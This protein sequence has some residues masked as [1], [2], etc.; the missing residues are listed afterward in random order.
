MDF[1]R[2]TIDGHDLRI[3]RVAEGG[4]PTVVMTNAFPQ[5]IRCWESLWDRLAER[6]D[7]V[8]VDLAGFG[9]S[10]GTPEEMRP[11]AQADLLVR[12]LDDLGIDRTFLVGPDVGVPVS[13][14]LAST[15]SERLHGVNV[16][17]G[18]GTWPTDFDPALGAAVRSRLVRWLAARAPMRRRLMAQNLDAA[19]SAGYHHFTPSAE[20]VEEYRSICFDEERHRNSLAFLGSYA[21]ELPKIEERLPSVTVPVLVTWGAH[22]RFVRPSNAERLQQLLPHS[23]LTV[24]EHAGHFSHEDADGEWLD[25]F[26][27]FVDSHHTTQDHPT[28]RSDR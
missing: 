23:E 28:L 4:R 27:A 8:A 13:L 6:V 26:L 10:S 14:W 18:P 22:D 17:D 7:L 5:S 3:A 11:S 19:T 25:R 2:R 9:R 15:H 1:E 20:A 16:Y 12:L 24:F 21:E